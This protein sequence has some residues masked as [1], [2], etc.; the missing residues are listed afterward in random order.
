MTTE[1][2]RF[3][4]CFEMPTGQQFRNRALPDA[5]K[6]EHRAIFTPQYVNPM[7]EPD[8]NFYMEPTYDYGQYQDWSDRVPQSSARSYL[9]KDPLVYP[10]NADIATG[11]ESPL[12]APAQDYNYI[13][14]QRFVR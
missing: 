14:N 13:L 7:R 9:L 10:S 2:R 11:G 1:R 3:D 12:L 5:F 6:K 4:R 8:R